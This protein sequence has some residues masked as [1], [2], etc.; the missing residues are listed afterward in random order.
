[1]S[2]LRLQRIEDDNFHPYPN[3]DINTYNASFE[4]E[5]IPPAKGAL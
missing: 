2:Q 3:V 5:M 1:M 4:A